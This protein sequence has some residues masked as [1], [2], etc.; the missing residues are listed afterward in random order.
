MRALTKQSKERPVE[1]PSAAT[2][3][4]A[5]LAELPI[6]TAAVL[7]R[8]FSAYFHLANVAEQVHRVRGLREPAGRRRLAGPRGRRVAD[9][10]GPDGLRAAHRRAGRASGLHRAPDRGQPPVDPDQAAPGRRRARR[11]DRR[12]ARAARAR[13]DRE[14]AEIVD[15]IWQTDELRQHRPTPLDEARNVV[16]YLQDLVDETLPELAADLAAELA[17]AR[18]RAAAPTP[19]R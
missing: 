17:A 12:R 18:R 14:L 9:E 4:A 7:V 15:L 5:L 2:R 1:R 19:A 6:D 13:Q 10:Q 8:A 11:A 16:Y 3:C